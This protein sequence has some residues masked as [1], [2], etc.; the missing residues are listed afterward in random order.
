MLTPLA[1]FTL[2]GLPMAAVSGLGQE[3]WQ[4]VWAAWG[5]GVETSGSFSTSSRSDAIPL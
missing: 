1:G 4:G 2:E 5:R 3:G